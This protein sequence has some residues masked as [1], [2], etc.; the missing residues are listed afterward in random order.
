[1]G[2]ES[3]FSRSEQKALIQ[4]GRLIV[5][6]D[7]HLPDVLLLDR[8]CGFVCFEP[9]QIKALL[10]QVP[11]ALHDPYAVL[12]TLALFHVLGLAR[13]RAFDDEDRE[14]VLLFGAVRN[15]LQLRVPDAGW[16]GGLHQAILAFEQTVSGEKIEKE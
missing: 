4:F 3:R 1:M 8:G 5:E 16:T 12:Y 14:E 2:W 6:H 10:T 15:Q 11:D 7:V 9:I 13:Q